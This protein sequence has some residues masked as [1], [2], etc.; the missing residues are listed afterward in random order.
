M[1][2]P[3]KPPVA[4]PTP[5]VEP[6]APPPDPV[7]R[8][9][10]PP[11]ESEIVRA[12]K[13]KDQ[14]IDTQKKA[15]DTLQRALDMSN[16]QNETMTAMLEKQQDNMAALQ[17]LVAGQ[18]PLETTTPA[19]PQAVAA[20][21]LTV[22]QMRVLISEESGKS[23][24][25]IMEPFAAKLASISTDGDRTTF[26]RQATTLYGQPFRLTDAQHD[27][28]KEAMVKHPTMSYY[29]A[30]R[31]LEGDLAIKP[32]GQ[33]LTPPVPAPTT[34]QPQPV[35]PGQPVPQPRIPVPQVTQ[36]GTPPPEPS[37]DYKPHELIIA[38]RNAEEA[39]SK[40]DQESILMERIAQGTQ[41]PFRQ[42]GEMFRGEKKPAGAAAR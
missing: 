16:K 2:V 15:N 41:D 3:N 17:D 27:A 33:P 30:G 18:T 22:E 20:N 39:G 32:P 40:N 4:P 1:V 29:E 6:S 34:V 9:T 25:K 19:Q 37:K 36:P 28:V 10:Q 23:A 35:L 12:M 14:A 5:P 24:R 7:E 38:A 11:Q 21:A 13:A 26:E 8:H 31:F 42:F